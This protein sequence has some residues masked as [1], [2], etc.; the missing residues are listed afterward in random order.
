MSLLAEEM[1]D[2]LTA[3]TLKAVGDAEGF[4][5]LLFIPTLVLI[6]S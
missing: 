1:L 2:C 3:C 4:S 6:F 5:L